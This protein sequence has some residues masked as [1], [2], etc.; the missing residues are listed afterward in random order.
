IAA[1]DQLALDPDMIWMVDFNAAEAKGMALRITVPPAMVA[2]GI[3]SLVVFGVATSLGA[4]ST[5]PQPARLFH[6]PH[7]THGLAFRTTGA[8][9][10][11]RRIPDTRGASASR[12]CPIRR[13]RRT[14]HASARRSGCPALESRRRSGASARPPWTTTATC[15]A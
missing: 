7:Y 8:P 11:A 13:T 6:A 14:P 4:A 2:A 10:T 5:A 15:A 9:A 12:S 1:G 3:D